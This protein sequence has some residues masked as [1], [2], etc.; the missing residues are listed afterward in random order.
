MTQPQSVQPPIPVLDPPRAPSRSEDGR[1]PAEPQEALRQPALLV[2]ATVASTLRSFLL[3]FGRHFR[4]QG[5]RVDAMASGVRGAGDLEESFDSLWEIQWTRNPL[6][7][8]NLTA[9]MRTVREVVVGRQYDIVHVHTPVAAFVARCALRKIRRQGKP[10]VVYTAHGFHFHRR[11][12]TVGNLAFRALERIA[13]RWTDH[14]VVINRED[15]EAACDHRILPA[16]RIHPM[17]GI[18][19][20]LEQYSAASAP[21]DRVAELRKE[22]GLGC[23]ERLLVMVAEFIPRKRHRDLLLAFAQLARP[24][25]HLALA[26]EGPLRPKTEALAARLGLSAR[27]HFLGMRRDVAVLMRAAEA[28]ILPSQQEGLPRCVMESMCLHTPVIGTRIRGTE[29]LIDDGCGL[30]F[31]VGDIRGLAEAMA[32]VLDHPEAMRPMAERA[33]QRMRAYDVRQI[34]DR[35]EALYRRALQ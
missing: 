4:K 1:R 16:D 29:E 8:R 5:W 25:V 24:D 3:P 26:G 6:D 7:P 20:D 27:V 15:A 22:L 11:G 12:S 32:W 19:V 9:A 18:G 14:L 21:P 28:T 17:P 13:G 23:A 34:L 31:E 10:K 30:A 2:V 33:W 35:H